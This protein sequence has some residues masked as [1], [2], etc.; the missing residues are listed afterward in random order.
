MDNWW[1]LFKVIRYLWNDFLFL[2]FSREKRNRIDVF[3]L[4]IER[5][6]LFIII[7]KRKF[8]SFVGKSSRAIR[9]FRRGIL[10]FEILTNIE[11]FFFFFLSKIKW[12]LDSRDGRN[13]DGWSW[14]ERS[15]LDKHSFIRS[16]EIIAINREFGLRLYRR[17]TIAANKRHSNLEQTI[18]IFSSDL[19][20]RYDPFDNI[21]TL[22]L[23][24][25]FYCL[26]SPKYSRDYVS[27]AL[28][29]QWWSG[30]HDSYEVTFFFFFLPYF[31]SYQVKPINR[32]SLFPPLFFVK[33]R[34]FIFLPP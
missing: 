23:S 16:I 26:F 3:D 5:E 15:Y 2:L 27:Y 32:P 18:I 9:N 30:M 13:F 24:F 1:L 21:S 8:L 25:I 17:I 22:L 7:Y 34:I 33:I 31:W 12:L 29:F 20:L 11:A 10:D 28:F 14:K 6:E 4:R 19:I